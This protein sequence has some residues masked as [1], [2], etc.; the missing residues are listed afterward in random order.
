MKDNFDLKKHSISPKTL[1]K[2]H[3]KHNYLSK[4]I[5]HI[6]T[7]SFPTNHFT[8]SIF[9]N[10]ANRVTEEL[11]MDKLTRLCLWRWCLT[12]DGP[13][14]SPRTSAEGRWTDALVEQQEWRPQPPTSRKLGVTK[15][16]DFNEGI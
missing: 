12:C 9:S 14:S 8:L 11:R 10:P 7:T 16:G 3:V 5:N 15:R 1:T 6:F 13:L 4:N 2:K